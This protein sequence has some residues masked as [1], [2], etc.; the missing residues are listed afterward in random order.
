MTPCR[1][2]FNG[3]VNLQKSKF[4]IFKKIPILVHSAKKIPKVRTS[5]TSTGHP[6]SPCQI[7]SESFN[8]K[9]F[10]RHFKIFGAGTND[11]EMSLEQQR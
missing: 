10:Y 2:G 5:K 9:D 6:L 8:Y 11:F 1:V 7:L 4:Q 3:F